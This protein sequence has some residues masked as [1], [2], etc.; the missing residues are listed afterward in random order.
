MS[1]ALC[2][3]SSNDNWLIGTTS[4]IFIAHRGPLGCFVGFAAVLL[5]V[6]YAAALVLAVTVLG[7]L[8]FP[9]TGVVLFPITGVVLFPIFGV[10][11]LVEVSDFILLEVALQRRAPTLFERD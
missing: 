10:L 11:L 7:V 4:H 8:L 1:K 6:R 5:D 2:S 3:F 9:I